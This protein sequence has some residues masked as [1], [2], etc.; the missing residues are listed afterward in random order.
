MLE[1]EA[2]NSGKVLVIG[3]RGAMGQAPENTMV[4]FKKG[5]ELGADLLELDIHLS[6]DRE[7]VVIHDATVERTTAGKG[8][9]AGMDLQELKALDAGSWFGPE[10]SGA[11]IPTLRE[12]LDWARDR[13]HLVIEIKGD[14]LPGAGIEEALIGLL[15]EFALIEKVMAISFHHGTVKRIKEIEPALKT[16]ILFTGGLIDSV[17]AARAASAD[18]LRPSRNYWSRELVELAHEAGLTA[19]T[20]TV[21][22]AEI[23]KRLVEI[24]IDSIV[25]NYPDR[26]R[27]HLNS[28]GKSW[29]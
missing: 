25:T 14:P 7:L 13:T 27:A 22:D 15:K 4:S 10:H 24:G 21:N 2:A 28:I 26:L 3:H 1:I 23:M 18:S 8:R 29:S 19:S 16:G 17:G 11:R 12:V 5:L 9:V 20:W 6:L